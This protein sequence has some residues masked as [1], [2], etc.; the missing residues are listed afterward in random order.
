MEKVQNL[1]PQYVEKFFK[2][3]EIDDKLN[4]YS[5]F[6]IRQDGVVLYHNNKLG[7]SLTKS[8]IGA[9]L[10]G[11]WQASKAL[12][13]FIPKTNQKN[14]NNSNEDIYRLSFD[15]TSQGIY[16]LPLKV[17]EEELFLGLIYHSEINPGLVK[18]KI[19]EL[20]DNLTNFLVVELKN[21]T[22]LKQPKKNTTNDFLFNDITDA[23]MDN[24]F[25]F[26]SK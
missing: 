14:S 24:L 4:R 3:C 12:S 17:Y 25:T 2:S 11:V 6:L 21:V 26:S 10:G 19:R 22:S 13:D 1:I 20:A 23:E 9:L 15:T 7:N 16:V 18:N 8:S 5:F